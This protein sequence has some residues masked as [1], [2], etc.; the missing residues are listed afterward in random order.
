M[1]KVHRSIAL[2][3]LSLVACAAPSGDDED[4]AG[5]TEDKLLAGRK[6]PE[7]E[8]ARILE[9]AGFPDDMVPAM[10]CTAKY[11]SSFFERASNKN[12]NGTV[13]RGLLQVNSTHLGHP[14]CP[15]TAE[16]LYDASANARCARVIWQEQGIR[17][18]YGYRKHQRECDAYV[19]DGP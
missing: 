10:V 11:E 16:G 5:A 4:L 1:G 15:R 12:K 7:T 6:I 17:A 19:V 8:V 18:W 3:V 14:S 13:D 9:N 2:I